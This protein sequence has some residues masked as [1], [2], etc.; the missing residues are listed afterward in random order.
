[1][2]WRANPKRVLT[3]WDSDRLA[4]SCRRFSLKIFG[5]WMASLPFPIRSLRVFGIGGERAK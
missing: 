3:H 5:M 2:S 1:M 4:S